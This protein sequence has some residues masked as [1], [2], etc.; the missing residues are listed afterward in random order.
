MNLIKETGFVIKTS[1]PNG[2]G[3]VTCGVTSTNQRDDVIAIGSAVVL[4]KSRVF[5]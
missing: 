1:V 5:P 2:V 4:P 3:R